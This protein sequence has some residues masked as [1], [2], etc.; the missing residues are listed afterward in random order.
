MNSHPTSWRKRAGKAG[1]LLLLLAVILAGCEKNPTLP[2]RFP[3]AIEQGD[4]CA[5]CGMYI[6]GMPGPRGEAY[7]EGR[8]APLKFGSTRDFFAYVL[9]PEHQQMLQQLFVQDAATIA[10]KHPS[11]APS[12]FTDARK[13]WYVAWQPMPGGMGPTLA[14]FAKRADAQAFVREHGGEMLQ[15]GQVTPQLVSLLG[16][17]CPGKA[18]PAFGLAGNCVKGGAAVP[19]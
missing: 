13:A 16:Y 19:H 18:S 17:A 14:S 9:E 5:V 2:T 4:T 8:R 11:N 3:S 15:F 12:T 10:W 1:T 7:V 6:E